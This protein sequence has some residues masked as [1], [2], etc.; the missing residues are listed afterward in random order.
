MIARNLLQSIRLLTNATRVFAEKCIDG[1]KAN[2]DGTTHSAESTLAAATALNPHIGYDKATEIVQEAA[3]SGRPL[4]E[5]AS[6]MGVDEET[7][8]TAMD[9]RKMAQGNT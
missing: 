6:E 8:N 3:R 5:V 9:L 4:R 2:E 1:I 7:Y